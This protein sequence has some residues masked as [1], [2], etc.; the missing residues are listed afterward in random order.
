[1]ASTFTTNINLQKQGVGDNPNT[2]GTLLNTG[3]F[4]IVDA[5][6]GS[7]FSQAM[8]S[9]DVI[10]S[11]TNA[12]N[13]YFKI[14]GTL[15]ANVN[16]IFPAT[17][18]RI[19]VVN[20]GT[21]GAFTLTVKPS[22]G[23]GIIIPQTSTQIVL[24]DSSTTTAVTPFVSLSTEQ[25][26]ASASTTDLGTSVTNIVS[27]TGTTTITS[28]GSSASVGN[29]LYFLRFTGA[30]TLTQNAT[31]LILPAAAN[32]VTVAG[33]TAIVKYEGSGNWRVVL[34]QASTGSPLSIKQAPGT[35]T[36]DSASA[37]NLGEY[38]SSVVATNQQVTLT[39]GVV[40]NITSI[41]LTAGDWDVSGQVH[42]NGTGSTATTALVASISQTS[43]AIASAAGQYNADYNTHAAGF[44]ASVS[45]TLPLI[46]N[47]ISL[48]ITTTIYLVA[49]GNITAGTL[50]GW[51]IIR[52]RRV[53]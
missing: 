23:T 34:Y 37:G 52:A 8:T 24:I 44:F 43:A 48:A 38:I 12:G 29:P 11:T 7:P 36:N 5:A 14:T 41:S 47:R 4:D 46:D 49:Q 1:M 33:D 31:S 39:N 10:L 3:V 28:F 6:L 26:L 15:T 51:G 50:A 17:A 16:L 13:L 21:T 53:R 25:T 32:I 9:S 18:G 35:A 27:I 19:I 45:P 20:N 22:G 2:W 40:A 42:I 30:L